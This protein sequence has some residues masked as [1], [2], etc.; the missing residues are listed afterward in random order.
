[1]STDSSDAE[2]CAYTQKR[3]R[4]IV[5]M[6]ILAVTAGLLGG[7]FV[8]TSNAFP[9]MSFGMALILTGNGLVVVYGFYSF[10]YVSREFKK[11]MAESDKAIDILRGKETEPLPLPEKK[12]KSLVKNLIGFVVLYVPALAVFIA[13]IVG[14][15]RAGDVTAVPT[16]MLAGMVFCLFAYMFTKQ[17]N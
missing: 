8:P 10:F 6:I 5:S 1:M 17:D 7:F 13:G 14:A 2:H 3:F 16:V 4:I 15:A 11:V 9:G 12:P